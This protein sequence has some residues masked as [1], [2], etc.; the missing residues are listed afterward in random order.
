MYFAGEFAPGRSDSSEYL[1]IKQSA[2]DTN[3]FYVGTPVKIGFSPESNTSGAI[4]SSF[5][6]VFVLH[7]LLDM[8]L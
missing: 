6:S 3:D 4:D 8:Y 2:M 5:V 1:D 7:P